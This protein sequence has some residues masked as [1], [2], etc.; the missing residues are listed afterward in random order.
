MLALQGQDLLGVKWSVGLRAPGVTLKDVDGALATGQIVRSWPMRGTL[1]LVPG[2]DLG[3]M[4]GVTADRVLRSMASRHRNLGLDQG[5]A[6]RAADAACGVLEGGRAATRA[7]LLAAF[8]AS[9][10]PVD[11]QR[12][13]HLLVWLHHTGLLCLG[14]MQG[15]G[16]LVVLLDEWVTSPRRLT[17]DEALGEFAARYFRSHGPAT[18]ADFCWWTKLPLGVGRRGLGIARDRLASVTIDDQDY[19]MAPGLPDLT[20]G[21]VEVLP[22]FDEFLLGYR[23]RS[24]SLAEQYSAAIVPG[25]NGI[26]Q[27]TIVVDGRVVG[28]WRRRRTT[29]GTT[30]TPTLFEP[31][32]A[33]RT[34]SLHRSFAGYGRFLGTDTTVG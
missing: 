19:W 5:S 10:L 22:G 12:G 27:P 18:I 29:A 15:S 30:V 16:Q 7:E 31:L 9:G 2:E 3:W 33:T 17:G 28:T 11:G 20:A 24:L 13:V 23:D 32:S 6:D 4:L 26:F 8:Q 25:N 21:R 34:V 14:A 1:H